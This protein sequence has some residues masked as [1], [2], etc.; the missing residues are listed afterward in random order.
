MIGPGSDKNGRNGPKVRGF[1]DK[2]G[3]GLKKVTNISYDCMH[4]QGKTNK[5]SSHRPPGTT[6]GVT[7][8]E[9]KAGGNDTESLWIDPLFRHDDDD[10]DGG[11]DD[12]GDGG[13]DGDDGDDGGGDGDDGD[14]RETK[15]RRRWRLHTCT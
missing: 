10:D 13:G 5:E 11:D 15:G 9:W 1:Y 7:W 4:V 3:T 6:Q 14:D 12:G 2:R 8:S